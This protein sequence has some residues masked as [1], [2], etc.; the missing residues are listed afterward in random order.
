MAG[1]VLGARYRPAR[2][3]SAAV[4]SGLVFSAATSTC[5]MAAILAKLPCNQPRTTDLDATLQA[6]GR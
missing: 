4:G 6:L 2:W 3:L 5:G 1:L